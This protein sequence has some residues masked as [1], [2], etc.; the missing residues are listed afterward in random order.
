MW[1]CKGK[2]PV[3]LRLLRPFSKSDGKTIRPACLR[4]AVIARGKSL[5]RCITPFPRTSRKLKRLTCSHA[6]LL[7]SD[8]FLFP[9]SSDARACGTHRRPALLWSRRAFTN[10]V[11]KQIIGT[12][13]QDPA[14]IN[15]ITARRPPNHGRQDF[16]H[17]VTIHSMAPPSQYLIATRRRGPRHLWS[18]EIHRRG[19]P[20]GVRISG[21]DFASET[22][23]RLAG[24]QALK[25]LLDGLARDQN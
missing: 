16:A 18:W 2:M 15:Q 1:C 14:Q 21:D 7:G 23:A 6:A 22:E 11:S 20:M 9:K 17:V 19:K 25:E 12:K 3:P 10:G 5:G 13:N 8:T 4:P 24:Q